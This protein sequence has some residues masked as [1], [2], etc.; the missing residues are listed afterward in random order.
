M[1]SFEEQRRINI[2]WAIDSLVTLDFH[3]RGTIRNIYSCMIQKT[4]YP[5]TMKAAEDLYK[6][7]QESE[8]KIVLIGTGFLIK[9]TMKPETDGPTATA[10]TARAVSLLGGVPVI[11]SQRESRKVLTVTCENAELNICENVEEALETP[12]PVVLVDMPPVQERESADEVISQML[13]LKPCAMVSI[14]HPGKGEDGKYYSVMGYELQG[15]P[16]P[17]DDLFEMVGEQGGA[18]IGIG[19]AGN[20]AGMGFAKPEIDSLTPYGEVTSSKVSCKA[21]IIASVS[22]FGAYGLI[23][24]LWVVSGKKVL[25]SPDLEEKVVQAAA[26]AGC[27]D[28]CTGRSNPGLD[29]VDIKYVRS[30]VHL[31]EAIVVCTDEFLPTRPFFI[32][33]HRGGDIGKPGKY[34]G[35][36]GKQK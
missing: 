17:V 26:T 14:E 6:A 7:I 18:T 29:I 27:L 31:L 8:N 30:L 1:R 3:A 5:L 24:A 15:W 32:D 34:S 11:V 9:P 2:G 16:G 12:Y 19:D 23:A 35:G 28:G 20:E 33:F 13:A 10:L 36:H 21:P 25:Q 22:E 4:E